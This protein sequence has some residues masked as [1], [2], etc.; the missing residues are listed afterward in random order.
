MIS[1]VP[2]TVAVRAFPLLDYILEK[3]AV[4]GKPGEWDMACP[5]CGKE[6]LGVSLERRGWHCWICEEYAP[7]PDGKRRAVRGAGGVIA[8]V[9]W[10]EGCTQAEAMDFVRSRA[11]FQTIDVEHIERAREYAAAA[12]ALHAPGISWPEGWQPIHATL[13]YLTKR[14]ITL[15]MAQAFRL[16]WCWG[17][18]YN[19]RLIFPVLENGHLVYYQ[20]RAMWEQEQQRGRYIK[21]LNPAAQSGLAAATDVLFN[22]DQARYHDRVCLVEGPIDAVKVGPDAVATFGK[23]ISQRQLQKLL[24]AGVQAVDLMWDGP[25]PTEPWGAWP[26]MVRVGK[27]LASYFDTRLVFI[28]GGDPGERMPAENAWLRVNASR[29]VASLSQI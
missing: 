21:A 15:E 11:Q 23:R 27:E 14:G 24:D 26:E 5:V 12:R 18:R 2:L 16:G 20:A 19:G 13:P 1:E 17:G 9:E 29:P 3:G 25:G 8:L 7:G 6:K 10:L 22:L 4:E 28:P